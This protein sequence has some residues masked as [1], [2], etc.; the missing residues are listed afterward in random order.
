MD[1]W[2]D[3]QVRDTRESCRGMKN[4]PYFVCDHLAL[5]NR[6]RQLA[7]EDTWSS[8]NRVPTKVYGPSWASVGQWDWGTLRELHGQVALGDL[9][10]RSRGGSACSFISK[11]LKPLQ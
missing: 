2:R 4:A 9:Q 1:R 3:T 8:G 6:A 11:V 10:D 5:G 7:M